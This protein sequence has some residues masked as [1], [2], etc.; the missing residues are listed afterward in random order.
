MRRP[1]FKAGQEN[2]QTAG[3]KWNAPGICF[4]FVTQD[5]ILPTPSGRP[6][7]AF[8]HLPQMQEQH[9]GE[10]EVSRSNS[11]VTTSASGNPRK[12][13]LSSRAFLEMVR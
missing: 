10:E 1:Y 13:S 9:L 7:L 12:S 3:S 2:R 4:A 11:A 5:G 6:P 8:G